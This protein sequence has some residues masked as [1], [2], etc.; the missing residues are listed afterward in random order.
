MGS[1]SANPLRSAS[2]V[3]ADLGDQT[4]VPEAADWWNA[5]DLILWGG[6]LPVTRTPDAHFMTEAR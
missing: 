2:G 5:S 1:L 6:N 3:T 4:D